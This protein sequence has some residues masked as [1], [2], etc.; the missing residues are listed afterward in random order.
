[1][2]LMDLLRELETMETNVD[3]GVDISGV[4]NDCR[5]VTPGGLFVAITGS[6]RD[7]HMF[8]GQALENGAKAVVCEKPLKNVPYIVVPDTREALYRLGSAFMGHPARRLKMVGVTGTNGKTTTTHILYGLLKAAGYTPGLVGTNHVLYG[9]K[10]FPAERTT[11]DAIALHTLLR[12]MADAGCTHCVMEVSSHALEQRR[13]AGIHYETAIFTNL[14]QDH[15]DYHPTLEDYFRAK[16]L[17]FRQCGIGIVNMDDPYG[18]RLREMTCGSVLT[19]AADKEASF[20]AR[21]ITEASDGVSFSLSSGEERRTLR[22]G[23]PGRFSVYNALA[24]AAGAL[25]LGVPLPVIAQAL[26]GIPSV[27]G[28]MEVVPVPGDFTVIIDYAHTPDALEN[29]LTTARGFTKGRVIAVFGCGGDRDRSK[30]PRMGEIAARLADVAVV[31]SDNPRT[32]PP[33][34]IIED[35]LAG[36]AERPPMVVTDRRAAVHTV[37]SMALPGDTVMLCGKGHELYQE[38]N[39]ITYPMDEREI[40]MEH[41]RNGND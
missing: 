16:A 8:V 41:W 12:D 38:I 2:L 24:A 29:V 34:R 17:L 6:A 20:Q 33:E 27:S 32:E 11:P 9:G 3:L 1:M 19:Y 22:W 21:E 23:T 13:V 36:M 25:C 4:Y 37:L 28:R 26:P 39:G 31:T 40:V 5:R 18:A 30:R 7:G 10:E 14:T 35:I 15:L